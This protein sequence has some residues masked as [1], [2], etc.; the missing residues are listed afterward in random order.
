MHS[1]LAPASHRMTGVEPGRGMGVAMHGRTTP[2]IRPSRSSARGHDRPGVPRRDRRA[3]LAVAHE[4]GGAHDRGV[5]L[6]SH[7]LR[8]VLVHRDHLGARD[9]RE[10]EGVPDQVGRP[11][12]DDG[13][14]ELVHRCPGPRDDV[15][16]RPVPAHRV[17]RDGQLRPGRQL[18]RPRPRRDP[19]T[20]RSS[21]RPRAASWPWRSAGRRC[22]PARAAASSTRAATRDFAFD[23]FRFGTAMVPRG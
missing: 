7:G 3:R 22:A 10:P 19:C 11:D 8:G 21:G 16:G 2:L 14:A 15:G 4:L 18:N 1:A 12:E 20:T 13:D 17:E 23:V 6:A 5:L 9:E